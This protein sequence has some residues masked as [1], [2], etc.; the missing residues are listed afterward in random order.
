M[1]RYTGQNRVGATAMN[2]VSRVAGLTLAGCVLAATSQEPRAK[3]SYGE[4]LSTSKPSDWRA[5]D[6]ANTVYLDLP[7]GRVVI[8]LAPKPVPPA[9]FNVNGPVP[10]GTPPL[11]IT[12]SYDSNYLIDIS[13]FRVYKS[14]ANLPF[15]LAVDV[16]ISPYEWLDTNGACGMG[17]YVVA[18]YVDLDGLTKESPPSTNSWYSQLC[19]LAPAP[20]RR[21]D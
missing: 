16:G 18:V 10:S 3:P 13:G 17:Y 6:P 20:N 21:S 15:A 2:W 7:A 19:P 5:A 9:P 8:E 1:R 12:W 11:T 4:L 14:I